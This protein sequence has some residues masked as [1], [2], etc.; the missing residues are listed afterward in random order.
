MKPLPGGDG[1][2]AAD[3][4]F[5]SCIP[6]TGMRGA[7]SFDANI[8]LGRNRGQIAAPLSITSLRRP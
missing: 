2:A 7:R 8:C 1:S 3:V 5:R 4:L 6:Y